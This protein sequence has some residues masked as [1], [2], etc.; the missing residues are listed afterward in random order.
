M[1]LIV[2]LGNPGAAYAGTRHN[3]GFDVVDELAARWKIGLTVEKFHA[4]FG[5]GDLGG[6]RVALLKP[7]TWMNRSGQA[8]SAAG[9]FYKLAYSDLLV[10]ADDLALPTGRLRMRKAGSAGGHN[11]LQSV[12]DA[13]GGED[14]CRLRIGIGDLVGDPTA[15]VLSR[16]ST[17]EKGIMVAACRRAAD[18]V[19]CWAASGAD[20]TM[21]RF[22]GDV[23]A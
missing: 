14:W 2:G 12:L 22:N 23:P 16:F 15:Y 13:V 17:E 1:K 7:T 11:G 8:V 18:A 10:I 3:V 6:E 4:W 21:T 19:E 9:R 20:L 5:Q